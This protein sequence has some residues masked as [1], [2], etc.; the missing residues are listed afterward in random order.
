MI[1]KKY[2]MWNKEPM[3]KGKIKYTIRKVREGYL[4]YE[5]MIPMRVYKKKSD[6]QAYVKSKK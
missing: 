5:N 4:I 2:S 3:H 6:A 1:K